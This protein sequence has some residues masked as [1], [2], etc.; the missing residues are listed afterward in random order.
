MAVV[1][2]CIC[3]YIYIGST[4]YRARERSVIFESTFYT[5]FTSDSIN[6]YINQTSFRQ[7]R[8]LRQLT[9][10]LPLHS[11]HTTLYYLTIYNS[12]FDLDYLPRCLFQLYQISHRPTTLS[13][14]NIIS[15]K[16]RLT[17]VTNSGFELRL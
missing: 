10:R 8:I 14:V 7:T 15:Q 4:A 9:V 11:Y 1:L 5:L 3:M 17:R 12:V 13:L 16:T 6:L 2:Y